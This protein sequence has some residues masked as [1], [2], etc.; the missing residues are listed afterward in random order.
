MARRPIR[1][2]ERSLIEHLLSTVKG[3]AKYAIPQE[4]E[5][6]DSAG[7]GGIQLSSRGE[8]AADLVEAEYKDADGREVIIT[9]T[10]NEHGE[11]FEMDLWKTDFS[12]LQRYPEPAMLKLTV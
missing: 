6:M 10:T 7:I 2:E 11:L 8:H 4:V 12:P 9:L 3:G 5:N 1:P